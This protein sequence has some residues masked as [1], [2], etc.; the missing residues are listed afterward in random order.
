MDTTEKVDAA[1]QGQ[2]QSSSTDHDLPNCSSKNNTAQDQSASVSLDKT[3]ININEKLKETLAKHGIS[4]QNAHS[5]LTGLLM[6]KDFKSLVK[7]KLDDE[8]G[9]EG[10]VLS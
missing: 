7:S 2:V 5:F 8:E 4:K 3:Q 10:I 9:D 6:D 1:N